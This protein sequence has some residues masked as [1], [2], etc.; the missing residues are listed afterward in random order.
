MTEQATRFKQAEDSGSRALM[1]GF[2]RAGIASRGG[3]I[4]NCR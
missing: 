4:D 2:D 1:A 3:S